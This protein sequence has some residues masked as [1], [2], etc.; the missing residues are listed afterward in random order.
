MNGRVREDYGIMRYTFV[1]SKGSSVVNYVLTS[2]DLF[3][4]ISHF[5]V[6]DPNILADHCLLTFSFTL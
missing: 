2:Q 1:G 4:N 3:K 6:H 5:E